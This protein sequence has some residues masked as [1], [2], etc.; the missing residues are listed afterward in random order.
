M[1]DLEQE[2]ADLNGDAEMEVLRQG[3]QKI[4]AGV[5]KHQREIGEKLDEKTTALG[6]QIEDLAG[7]TNK[8]LEDVLARM[9]RIRKSSSVL[10][11]ALGIS[12][13][14]SANLRELLPDSAKAKMFEFDAVSRTM[15]QDSSLRDPVVAA[16][17]TEWFRRCTRTQMPRQFSATMAEDAQVREKLFAALQEKHFG[18]D[19]EAITKT[20]LSEGAAAS[21]ATLVPTIVEAD[22][23]R[24][25]KDA[26]TLYPLA[27]QFQM[28]KAVHDVPSESTACTVNWVAEAG[29][30]T[31]GEPNLS[32]KTLTAKKLVGRATMSIELVE[33]SNVGLLAYLLEVF[34]EKMGGELDKQSVLG[35]GSQPAITGID[36]TANINVVSSSAT[37]AG[38]NL[39]WQL[40]VNTFTAAG[41]SSQIQRG[42]WIMSP[43]GYAVCL[44]LTDSTGQPIVRFGQAE[45]APAGTLIGR[46]I[47]FSN[48]WGGAP[49]GVTATLDDSTNTN[50]KIIY[51]V[52]SSL[53][54]GTRM[55]MRW[56]VTDQ[57]NW[58]NFQMDARLVGRFGIVVGV[59]ADFN[60]LTKVNYT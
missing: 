54:F 1:P 48:R 7:K 5:V 55:G 52:P 41:E 4:A 30:L 12:M 53:L 22:L 6:R 44:G 35:D 51:G 57:V 38:R 9:E 24:Q 16:A 32:K 37:A 36:N 3:V 26:S 17:V 43:K 33:D 23:I 29:T 50:T 39:T 28:T 10:D 14:D 59:P 45:G 31:A 46:P 15:P 56:E 47:L 58:A 40:L 13:S 60:R 34:T 2:V 11:R 27:R 49:S 18:S 8:S 20:A 19:W 25:I 21:G 42:Y